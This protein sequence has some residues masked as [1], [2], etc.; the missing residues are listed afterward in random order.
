MKTQLTRHYKKLGYSLLL[1]SF[2]SLTACVGDLNLSQYRVDGLEKNGKY[3]GLSGDTTQTAVANFPE[4]IQITFDNANQEIPVY[5]NGQTISQHFTRQAKAAVLDTSKVTDLLRQGVNTLSVAPLSFGPQ[6]NFIFDNAGP[7]IDVNRIEEIAGAY[8]IDLRAVDTTNIT[9]LYIQAMDYQWDGGID[10]SQYKKFKTSTQSVTGDK[11][12][13]TQQGKS[14]IWQAGNVIDA[15]ASM[16][17]IVAKDA[18]GY[19]TR[20]Y[21]LAPEQKI[22]NIFKMAL[23]KEVT[24]HFVPMAKSKIKDMH[25]YAP[26]E[27]QFRGQTPKSLDAAPADTLDKLS[28]WE[29]SGGVYYGSDYSLVPASE[30]YNAAAWWYEAADESY[31]GFADIDIPADLK[32]Q[33]FRCTNIKQERSGVLNRKH[34]CSL[35]DLEYTLAP[36]KIKPGTCSRIS[37]TEAKVGEAEELAFTLSEKGQGRLHLE[38]K[39]NDLDI[40]MGIRNIRCG[41][42]ADTFR[43]RYSFPNAYRDWGVEVDKN[44]GIPTGSLIYSGGAAK[45]DFCRDIGSP[46]ALGLVDLGD[47]NITASYSD[48]NGDVTVTIHDGDLSLKVEEGLSLGLSKDLKVGNSGVDWIIGALSGVL[49]N[50][51]VGIVEDTLKQNMKDF[52]LGFDLFTPWDDYRDPLLLENDGVINDPSLQMQAQGYQVWTNADNNPNTPLKWYMYYA[53]FLKSLK[54]HPD[55]DNKVLGSRYVIE[56]VLHP[57]ASDSKVDMAVNINMVNQALMSL[58]RSGMSHIT[59]TSSKFED[60]DGKNS[61][62]HFGPNI[63]DSFA[64]ENGDKRVALIPRSP[65]TIEM[66]TGVSGTQATIYYRNAKMNIETFKSNQWKR[67]FTVAVDMRIGVLMMAENDKFQIKVLGVPELTINTIAIGNNDDYI[68]DNDNMHFGV[69]N[70]AVKALVQFGVNMV[71]NVAIPRLS[72]EIGEWEYPGIPIPESDDGIFMTTKNISANN[73]QHLNFAL[74]MEIKACD[75]ET[76]DATVCQKQE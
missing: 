46:A 51:F 22:N 11:T 28:A 26:Q 30:T 2:L 38:A 71:L 10:T 33:D 55:L 9:E 40:R 57:V 14:N 32:K 16:Y 74:G 29:T 36:G 56:P 64:F 25:V 45:G 62:V 1:L 6:V 43:S 34:Y 48:V 53:G 60:A 73:N 66:R 21:Y 18:Y 8:Q 3:V 31:C 5:L 19:E 49:N 27:M 42:V 70:E 47:M 54:E 63:T 67:D 52:V 76:E 69:A 13:F 75:K 65:G 15:N 58:Y 35:K 37:L 72:E 12:F 7:L 24:D 61:N 17:M 50:M 4:Q 20:N 68:Y 41:F 39:I 23:D 44:T 59:V